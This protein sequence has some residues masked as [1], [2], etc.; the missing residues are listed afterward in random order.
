MNSKVAVIVLLVLLAGASFVIYSQNRSERMNEAEAENGTGDEPAASVSFICA[1]DSYFI[2]EFP[3]AFDEVSVVVDGE[4]VR[5]L[6][7][8]AGDGQRFE[9]DSHVYVFAGE[10]ATV[11]TKGSGAAT[12]CSQPFD[13]NNAPFNFGD[14]GEGGGERPDASLVV[15]ESI[16]GTWQSVDDEQFTREFRGDG[17]VID[18]YDGAEVSTGTW[19]AFTADAPLAVSF[20]LEPD[21]VYIRM[22]EEEGDEA[23]TLHFKLT[24]LTP[25]ELELVYM[26]RGGALRFTF[27]D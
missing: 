6:P 12:T 20:P 22:A 1:D 16:L 8:V 9:T 11:T 15:S 24:T 3:A 10:E 13:P 18:R 19:I 23:T 4:T 26:E 2:A 27:V 14:A 25:E 7:R 21:T 17:T 5:T